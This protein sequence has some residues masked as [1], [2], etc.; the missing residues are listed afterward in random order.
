MD[1][2]LSYLLKESNTTYTFEPVWQQNFQECEL[3]GQGFKQGVPIVGTSKHPK[4]DMISDKKGPF[5]YF[6]GC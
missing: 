6:P 5:D 3:W 1:F 2:I 4:V